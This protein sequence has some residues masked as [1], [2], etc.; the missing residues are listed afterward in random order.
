[1]RGEKG[2]VSIELVIIIG[3]V[4]FIVFSIIPSILKQ[5]ELN[6]GLTAARDGA[7]FGAGMRGLG[8]AGEGV[9]IAPEGVVKIDKIEH[10]INPGGGEGGR[11][12]VRV[13]IFVR[14][15]AY[16]QNT[17]IIDTIETQAR[18]YICYAF[19]GYWPTG[20]AVSLNETSG[21]YY[22]FSVRQPQ[23]VET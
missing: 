23:W 1:M 9:D 21:R 17:T 15:P 22:T 18:R 13:Y 8:Y 16:L 19:Q 5:N 2:Q 7:T 14:G 11:D 4:L 12:E 10:V 20:A 6:R 3:V